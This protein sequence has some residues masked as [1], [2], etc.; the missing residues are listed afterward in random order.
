MG[1]KKIV[2]LFLVFLLVFSTLGVTPKKTEAATNIL[3]SG[4]FETNFWE[5]GS[6]NVTT[7]NWDGLDI[8]H[9]NYTDDQWITAD[10]GNYALKYWVKDTVTGNQSFS[11]S[12][13]VTS[14]PAGSYQLSVR[15]MGGA[16]NEAGSITVFAGDSTTAATSTT[17]Y[18]SWETVTLNF[19]IAEDT[20][21]FQVGAIVEGAPDAWGI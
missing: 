2:R 15:S 16:D 5:D 1:I 11:V 21:N 7:S 8:Q 3:D 13:T 12:Q 4:G 19:D 9:F 20:T 18:N 6:W 14:L 17:G 10:T